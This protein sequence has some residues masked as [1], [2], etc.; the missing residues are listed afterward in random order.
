[1]PQLAKI[2]I[3]MA[4]VIVLSAPATVPLVLQS[5][6]SEC[7]ALGDLAIARFAAQ[8][9]QLSGNSPSAMM[10]RS[11]LAQAG[12]SLLVLAPAESLAA[13]LHPGLPLPLACVATYWQVSG[14]QIRLPAG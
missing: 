3:A 7:I 6:G 4:A 10:A 2:M 1:M 9:L 14:G 13:R 12:Q 8:N 5:T 11:L